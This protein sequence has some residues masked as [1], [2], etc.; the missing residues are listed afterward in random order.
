[1][2]G[3]L[4]K[5]GGSSGAATRSLGGVAC[6]LQSRVQSAGHPLTGSPNRDKVTRE[7][8]VSRL[9]VVL[10]T[11]G[12]VVA[13]LWADAPW[14]DERVSVRTLTSTGESTATAAGQRAELQCARESSIGE[15]SPSF[16]SDSS[17]PA[18]AK[19]A[20]MNYLRFYFPRLAVELAADQL[21]TRSEL[22][23]AGSKFGHTRVEYAVNGQ[24]VLG[25]DVLSG[26]GRYVVENFEGC[27]Y[28]LDAARLND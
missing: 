12:A 10:C 13:L 8:K 20:A 15:I 3:R 18:S 19:E 23:P 16:V 6:E 25:F 1:M 11:L 2:P 27:G 7:D 24:T 14:R 22:P 4:S 5:P 9:A 26:A 17:L 21:E 28:F